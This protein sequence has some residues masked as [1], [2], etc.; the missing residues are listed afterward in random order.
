MNN[1]VAVVIPCYKV[2][3]HILGVISSIGEEVT[4]IYVVD[5]KC[6]QETGSFV[7]SNNTDSRVKVI[8]HDENLGVGGAVLTGYIAAKNDGNYC[9]VKVDGDG[10]MDPKLIPIFVDPILNGTADYTKGNRFFNPE[11]V[12][13]MPIIRVI[14]NIS[15]SFMQKMSSGYW[16]LFDPTNGYTAIN[17]HLLELL[18]LDKI[19]KRYFFES[20]ILFRL[21]TINAVATDVPMKAIY[22]DEVSNLKISD[23]VFKFAYSH[24][25]NTCK[26]I[27]YKYYLRD[28]SVASIELPVGFILFI[29]G[30]VFGIINWSDSIHEAQAASSGTVML[31]ALPI[32]IGI[33]LLLSFLEYDIATRPKKP[34]AKNMVFYVKE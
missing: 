17:L 27:F 25:K 29:Y 28:F 6:P 23:V 30:L 34:I 15:L 5:D 26:R 32:I 8:F 21:G 19:A 31:A 12:K 22:G 4:S 9:A 16:D 11:D 18:P 24:L 14:G 2:K 1:K 7:L 3:D 13:A 20:D 10:Q 33:Q